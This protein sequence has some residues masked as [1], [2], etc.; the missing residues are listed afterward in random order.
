VTIETLLKTLSELRAI[1]DRLPA[2][3]SPSPLHAP[4][5]HER[6]AP[7]SIE[8]L[9]AS[10]F[11]PLPDDYSSFLAVC[12]G[13]DAMDIFNGYYLQPPQF[14]ERQ[15][16]Q[17]ANFS[18]VYVHG[19]SEPALPIGGNGGGDL[20]FLVPTRGVWRVSHAIL[21]TGG[22]PIE[23]SSGQWGVTN[24]GSSFL[25][26]LERIQRDWL[27]FVNDPDSPWEYSCG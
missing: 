21:S 20:F 8:S 16:A 17:G 6:A 26:F 12:G 5:F 3:P 4:T 1:G 22:E 10:F 9:E 25:S 24:V 11:S 27:H 2:L 7:E 15:M 19:H 14:V 23:L 18:S 13:F